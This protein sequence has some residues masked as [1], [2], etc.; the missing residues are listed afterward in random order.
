MGTALV[1]LTSLILGG[2]IA[3]TGDLLGRRLGKKRLSVFGLRPKHTAILLT[4]VTGVL[5]SGLT[6]G[7]AMAAVP[8][9]RRAVIEGEMLARQNEQLEVQNTNLDRRNNQ[10]LRRNESLAGTNRR[11]LQENTTLQ[12]ENGHLQGVRAHLLRANQTLKSEGARL[13]RANAG[14][15]NTN[16]G[17]RATNRNLSGLNVRLQASNNDLSVLNDQY[18]KGRYIFSANERPWQRIVLAD[19]PR[20][21]LRSAVEALLDEAERMAAERMARSSQERSV[22]YLVRPESFPPARSGDRRAYIDWIVDGAAKI[23]GEQV[24][25]EG[26]V[27]RNCVE[28]QPVP[29]KIVVRK[30]ELVF[31][32]GAEI[33]AA[34]I[35]GRTAD[36]RPLSD[37]QLVS[38]VIL[39]LQERVRRARY[40]DKIG[41]PER[42]VG[43]AGWDQILEVCRRVRGL[44]GRG[45]LIARARQ[46]TRAAGPLNLD[47]EVK[48]A[49]AADTEP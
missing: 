34:E 38:E 10:L 17:L 20:R 43:E 18:R 22:V 9:I 27:E 37:G 33:A 5:I 29:V 42:Y 44:P 40:V 16:R 23:H 36:G 8:W 46:D 6:F 2:F 28:G 21:I 14:L 3:Y 47:L 1:I 26:V 25:L 30:N 7:V 32:R 4:I 49:D 24:V 45:V 19:P 48:P 15:Q 35:T 41:G 39:F 11:R 12:A 31:A 13:E